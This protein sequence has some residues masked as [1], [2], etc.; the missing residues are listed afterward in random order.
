MQNKKLSLCLLTLASAA[1]IASCGGNKPASSSGESQAESSTDTSEPTSSVVSSD[2]SEAEV[3]PTGVKKK[4]DIGYVYV[5]TVL[6]GEDLFTFTPEGAT[7]Y[8][9]DSKNPE[10]A[11][12]NED[13]KSVT[14]IA[15]GKATIHCKI[16]GVAKAKIDITCVSETGA[17][18][19]QF[20]N[21]VKNQ[22][23]ADLDWR[24]YEGKSLSTVDL[25][26]DPDSVEYG[27]L[28]VQPEYVAD[29]FF[30]SYSAIRLESDDTTYG[31]ELVD[32]NGDPIEQ[33][34]DDT[35]F[36]DML[37]RAAAVEI[38]ERVSDAFID[39]YFVQDNLLD[40]TTFEEYEEDDQVYFTLSDNT[41]STEQLG[42]IFGAS[43]SGFSDGVTQLTFDEENQALNFIFA[44]SHSGS[45][46][47]SAEFI[48]VTL[49]VGD[50]AK[51]DLLEDAVKNAE[52]PAPYDY[53]DLAAHFEEFNDNFFAAYEFGYFDY[54][55]AELLTAE[56]YA[57]LGVEFNTNSR[58]YI[59][60][61]G[62]DILW[63][64]V[65]VNYLT[66]EAD[67][68]VN[69][70]GIHIDTENGG[71]YSVKADEE[72]VAVLDAEPAE[73]SQSIMS[74]ADLRSFNL[75]KVTA[76]VLAEAAPTPMDEL[77]MSFS[78]Q[79]SFDG[80]VLSS[81][82]NG[83]V[84]LSFSDDPFAD[85]TASGTAGYVIGNIVSAKNDELGVN[86]LSVGLYERLSFRDVDGNPFSALMGFKVTFIAPGETE[87][88]LGMKFAEYFGY[89]SGEEEESSEESSSDVSEV[90]SGESSEVS[91][92]ESSEGGEN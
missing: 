30:G 54:K 41:A 57:Q 34:E 1:L 38:G 31:Y 24:S 9:L 33:A 36:Q 28:I 18:V 16:N 37:D 58:G 26:E 62:N 39:L 87:S 2:E 35:C 68:E 20:A 23:R 63:S 43:F 66:G 72:G 74:R 67:G 84:P 78:Y 65:A 60:A 14:I 76:D 40:I 80:G 29:Y 64:N 19:Q 27:T 59:A 88:G 61:D 51:V 81:I 32:A 25:N 89:D 21:S 50:A 71:V 79:A 86:M 70:G 92:E 13:G 69:Y 53:T 6:T 5:G 7:A 44:F 45:E 91:S 47:K 15:S 83:F 12:L 42:N 3:V 73:G 82:F 17:K 48:N 4:T 22:F 56:D 75:A 85:P 10:V 77:G 49:T 52:P 90:T 55:T 11:A 8:T 46:G